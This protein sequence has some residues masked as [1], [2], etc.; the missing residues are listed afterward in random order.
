METQLRKIHS[1][2][3]SY[4][5]DPNLSLENIK[6]E[7]SQIEE[8]TLSDQM[9]EK[10]GQTFREDLI[11]LFMHFTQLKKIKI[12]WIE[13]ESGIMEHI[14]FRHLSC[15]E[16]ITFESCKF[17]ALPEEIYELKTLRELFIYYALE[18]DGIS[19]KINQLQELTCLSITSD[20]LTCLPDS[21]G[22][23]KN[24]QKLSIS[25]PK[26]ESVPESIGKLSKLVKLHLDTGKVF[27][28]SI[29]QLA[30]LEELYLQYWDDGKS[31]SEEEFS[32]HLK[33]TVLLLKNLKH[34]YIKSIYLRKMPSWFD[35]MN[36]LEG[37]RFARLED[38]QTL[39]SIF[40]KFKNL[41]S[42]AFTENRI[43]EIPEWIVELGNIEYLDFSSTHLVNVSLV[44]TK[45]PKLKLLRLVML[46]YM[47]EK[48]LEKIRFMLPK[49][50]VIG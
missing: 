28:K 32:E 47:E 2:I 13:E 45:L 8:F 31:F 27:P 44:V 30:N 22:E 25:T 39:P 14:P 50:E 19:D 11:L 23:L 36:Y 42:L 16:H 15:I 12:L 29:S 5:Y 3:K 33:V 38:E 7:L 9:I 40:R 6:V 21:I 24:L 4:E 17:K 10:L 18:V 43:T 35:Q 37:I 1:W 20:K 34:F 26:I 41:K 48:T 46:F 49:C